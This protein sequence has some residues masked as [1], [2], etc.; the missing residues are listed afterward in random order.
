[1]AAPSAS[2]IIRMPGYLVWGASDLGQNTGTTPA[3]GGTILDTVRDIEFEPR[4]IYREIFNERAG[5]VTDRKYCGEKPVVRA[6]LRH[7]GADMISTV[8]ASSVASGSQG[9]R[10]R[11]HPTASGA[12]RPGTSL[13]STGGT[14]LVVAKATTAKPFVLFR[15]AIPTISEAA[16]IQYQWSVEYGLEVEFHGVPDSSG[17]VYDNARLANLAL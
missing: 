14:L 13:F 12:T 2:N 11:F 16:R 7:P 9:I 1:M 6:V 15:N 5:A 4:I 8:A 3:F 17:Q 10:W